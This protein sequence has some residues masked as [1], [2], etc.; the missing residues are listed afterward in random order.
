MEELEAQRVF[1][2][3]DGKATLQ[4]PNCWKKRELTAQA[5]GARHRFK[6]RCNCGRMFRV[7]VEYREKHRKPTD[8]DGFILR[9]ED[10][11]R[12]GELLNE[13]IPTYLNIINCKVRN[14]SVLGIGLFTAGRHPFKVGDAI[15][16]RFTL[17]SPSRAAVAK[18]AV[19][20]T[21]QGQYLGCEFL[22]PDKHDK[23]LAFYLL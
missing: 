17:D 20:R 4:C 10:D 19:V 15:R 13:S 22:E 11:E 9:L 3:G 16:V 14:I 6:V 1:L 21:I 2:G 18:K 23:N 12:W 8:L 7:K 5:V